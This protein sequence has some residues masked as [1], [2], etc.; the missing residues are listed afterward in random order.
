MSRALNVVRARAV[1]DV[2]APAVPH[3]P[4]SGR[5]NLVQTQLPPRRLH[6]SIVQQT[7]MLDNDIEIRPVGRSTLTG[8]QNPL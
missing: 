6:R 7:I 3:Q 1:V 4:G 5:N 8:G 2:G